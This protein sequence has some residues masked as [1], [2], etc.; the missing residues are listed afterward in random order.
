MNRSLPIAGGVEN[1]YRLH[2]RIYD[3][4]RWAFLFGRDV[5]LDLA[6]D[7]CRPA[8]IL[9]IGCGTGRNLRRL[10]RLFP[11]AR[12]TGVDCSADMLDIARRRLGGDATLLQQRYEAPIGNTCGKSDGFDLIVASYALSMFNPGWEQAIDALC[13]DL[14]PSGCVALVDF[15][16]TPSRRFRQWMA[17]N[18]VRMEGH[19]LEYLTS[20]LIT[21]D[22][23]LRGAYG[24]LWRYG[25]YIGGGPQQQGIANWRR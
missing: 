9:E 15:H 16:D 14:R 10:Q 12:L 21:R 19:L 24:G 3:S 1:Y 11:S 13:R 2:A 18:H 8:N 17:M 5:I 20:R 23:A 22:L 25:L 4:S 7:Y 6:A